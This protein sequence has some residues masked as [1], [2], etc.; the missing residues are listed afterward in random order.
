MRKKESRRDW[1]DRLIK[2]CK[3]DIAEL[4]GD[5]GV[6]WQYVIKVVYGQRKSGA[7][8]P[9]GDFFWNMIPADVIAENVN[10]G[11]DGSNEHAEA[12]NNA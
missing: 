2:R 5:D 8:D 6:N 1:H 7:A 11:T 4:F 9:T 12:R 3:A 10:K